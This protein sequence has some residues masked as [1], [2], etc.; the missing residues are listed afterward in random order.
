MQNYFRREGQLREKVRLENGKGT[1]TFTSAE[2]ADRILKTFKGNKIGD[3]DVII[4]PFANYKDNFTVFMANIN[5]T[6]NEVQLQ[7]ILHEYEPII[8]CKLQSSTS[9]IINGTVTFGTEYLSAHLGRPTSVSLL[10]SRPI[11][12]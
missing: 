10:N 6:L 7:Q 12:P 5:P 3:W 11:N 1:V 4:R 8:S 9:R 2:V